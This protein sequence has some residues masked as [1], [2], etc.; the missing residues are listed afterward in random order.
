MLKEIKLVAYSDES[1][2]LYDKDR[3]NGF[4]LVE[5]KHMTNYLKDILGID[6]ERGRVYDLTV[7]VSQY[8]Q[9]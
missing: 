4:M 2:W 5:N 3:V 8:S 1:V 7:D 6:I 9:P